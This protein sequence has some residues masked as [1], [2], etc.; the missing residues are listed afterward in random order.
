MRSRNHSFLIR[1]NDK[2]F[3][4]L[5]EKIEKSRLPREV[6]IRKVLQE[7]TVREAP[8]ADYPKLLR[9]LSKIGN[10][11]N[12]IAATANTIHFINPK[13]LNQAVGDL[14]HTMKQIHR[15]FQIPD[16]KRLQEEIVSTLQY[17]YE[18]TKKVLDGQGKEPSS[19]EVLRFIQA[20]VADKAE[21]DN[22]SLR[23]YRDSHPTMMLGFLSE[24]Y[25]P[26]QEIT[27][28]EDTE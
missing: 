28:K 10:N 27:H 26:F 13:E 9:S 12:Q 3:S 25:I 6:F 20:A 16:Q 1:L 14:K 4:A 24:L 11:L 21:R 23:E 7:G 22:T 19:R 18:E 2:E 15:S 5:N 17:I 8:S